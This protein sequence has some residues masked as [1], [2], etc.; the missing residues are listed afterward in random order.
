MDDMKGKLLRKEFYRT[1]LTGNK[2]ATAFTTS[3]GLYVDVT[4][5]ALRAFVLTSAKKPPDTFT[6]TV[7]KSFGNSA[8]ACSCTRSSQ[9]DVHGQFNVFKAYAAHFCT[10][11][12]FLRSP[13]LSKIAITTI[14]VVLDRCVSLKT[15][16][17][18]IV[19]IALPK[20]HTTHPRIWD[21][22]SS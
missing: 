11:K 16:T 5:N 9:R 12:E 4:D 19:I 14:N 7:L 18:F 2:T 17:M 20:P 15:Q 10:P 22:E 13:Y 8:T 6:N 21:L 3:K 1:V